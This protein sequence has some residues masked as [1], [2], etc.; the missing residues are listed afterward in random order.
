M[1]LSKKTE[2]IVVKGNKKSSLFYVMGIYMDLKLCFIKE[3][4]YKSG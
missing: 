1:Y 4:Y 2:D 3:D